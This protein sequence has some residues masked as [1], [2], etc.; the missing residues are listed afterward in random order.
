MDHRLYEGDLRAGEENVE[1]A[2]EH[3]TAAERDVLLWAGAPGPMAP[4]GGDDHGGD[5]HQ[6]V[7][8]CYEEVA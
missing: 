5:G 4:A 3:R 8:S 6:N 2:G 7:S 1:G